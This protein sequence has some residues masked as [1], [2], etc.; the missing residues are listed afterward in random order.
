M[1]KQR[2]GCKDEHITPLIE[3]TLATCQPING[4]RVIKCRPSVLQHLKALFSYRRFQYPS[5]TIP[6]PEGKGDLA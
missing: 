1:Q 2:I 4:S 6:I 5:C 3:E